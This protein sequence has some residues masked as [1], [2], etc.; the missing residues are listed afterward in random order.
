MGKQT[1][2]KRNDEQMKADEVFITELYLKGYS[3]RKIAD[4]I[5]NDKEKSYTISYVSVGKVV[6][7]IV[8]QWKEES[9]DNIEDWVNL[10]LQKIANLEQ[11]YWEQWEE[12]K[13]SYKRKSTKEG[14]NSLGPYK[15]KRED[16]VKMIGDPRYLQ[17]VE[18]CI[19]KRCDLLG[20]DKPKEL[21]ITTPLEMTTFSYKKHPLLENNI[22]E[23][24]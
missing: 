10:E 1:G 12:S 19:Q 8:A 6:K 16:E 17:G 21:N 18:R 24:N 14:R 11:Q 3:Y 13:I 4:A 15:E 22:E 23:N 7:K 2:R 20:L 9:K 5:K